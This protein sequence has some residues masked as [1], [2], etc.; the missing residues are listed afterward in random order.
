[1]ST[2]SSI[3]DSV[4]QADSVEFTIVIDD[5]DTLLRLKEMFGCP[6]EQWAERLD[7]HQFVIHHVAALYKQMRSESRL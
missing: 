5:P 4:L 2:P 6:F 3:P 7:L 1:M